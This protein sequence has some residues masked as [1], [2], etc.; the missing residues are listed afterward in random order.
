MASNKGLL[1]GLSK[2]FSVIGAVI[3][4]GVEGSVV[5]EA[6]LVWFESWSML[7]VRMAG[8]L[9]GEGEVGIMVGFDRKNDEM[10]GQ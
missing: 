4:I 5:V 10:L 8:P 3:S 9:T 6:S 1:S 2:G 7:V